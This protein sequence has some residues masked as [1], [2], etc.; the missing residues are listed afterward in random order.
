MATRGLDLQIKIVLNFNMMRDC[1][2]TTQNMCTVQN[3]M[4]V[5]NDI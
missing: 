5:Q 1:N 4:S 3:V 2:K